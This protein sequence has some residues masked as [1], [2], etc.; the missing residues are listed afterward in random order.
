M[1]AK[2]IARMFGAF[3]L[4]FVLLLAATQVV[5]RPGRQ[6]K[7]QRSPGLKYEID[8]EGETLGRF[9]SVEG[10]GAETEVIGYQVESVGGSVDAPGSTRYLDFVARRSCLG[11]KGYLA[12]SPILEEWRQALADGEADLRDGSVSIFDRKGDIIWRWQLMRGFPKSWKV[13]GFDDESGTTE[14]V[15][16]FVVDEV[17]IGFATW[18][19][20]D[21]PYPECEYELSVDGVLLGVF[22]EA[23]CGTESATVEYQESGESI[24]RKLPGTIRASPLVLRKGHLFSSALWDWHKTISAGT[25]EVHDLELTRRSGMAAET[26]TVQFYNCWPC[27]VKM[28]SLDG[29]GSDI[30]TAEIKFVVESFEPLE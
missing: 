25:L 1:S 17:D 8:F 3:C 10:I 29:K 30:M 23:D 28:S 22:Q 20:S 2:S 5:S 7:P 9:P 27:A 6:V 21:R 12:T 16:E 14:E 18:A 11:K 19:P 26:T 15:I 24:V 13:N 4:L